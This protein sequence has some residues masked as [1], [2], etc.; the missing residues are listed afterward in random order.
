[1]Q[2][3]LE[4][5]A[6]QVI[7][8]LNGLDRIRFRGTKRLLSTVGG[9]FY[10]LRQQNV[11][12]KDFTPFVMDKT[13]ALRRGVEEQAKAW[14]HK[15]DYLNSSRTRKEDKA[16]E[17]AQQRGIKEGLVAVL[18]CV[19]PCRSYEVRKNREEQKLELCYQPMKCLHY[20]H[21]YLDRNF[22][23]VHTRMQSWFPF[24]VH[25][26]MNGREWLARQMD[27][28]GIGYVKKDNCFLDIADLPAAQKL[29]DQQLRTNWKKLLDGLVAQSNPAHAA[30]FRSL[31][32]PYYW[33]AEES[34]WASD[35]M[36]RSPAELASLM[37]RLVRHG[38]EVWKCADVLRFLGRREPE[39]YGTVGHFKG[40]VVTD[41]K[42]RPEG[43]RLLHRV[44]HN[45]LKIYDK[46]GSVLRVETVINDPRDLK[47]FRT[48]E[49]DKDGQ[50]RWLPLR[51]GV[52]DLH[53]RT[54][55]SQKANER[56]LDSLAT[57]EESQPLGA[58][59]QRLS[60]PAQ[61]AGRRVRALNPS[62]EADELLL[63]AVGR[64]EFLFNGFRNRDLRELLFPKTTDDPVEM[65]R[66]TA[67]VTRK[68]RIL[69]AHGLIQKVAKTT[70]YQLTEYGRTAIAA[71]AAA[72]VTNVK[73]LAAAA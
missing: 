22:G 12:L 26:C 56:C 2:K 54:Q 66:R 19:E 36:F 45:W 48:A 34:E 59:T 50:K 33:S 20:Y 61:L 24:T 21:Y 13:E 16:L 44:N 6:S 17:L 55:T 35:V 58:L 15:V 32:V 38:L 7:G 57:V 39:M 25:V 51:K 8:V 52:A 23:L 40:E 31:P 14:G 9:M 49:S 4:R 29:F 71:L 67:G 63:E 72:K 42:R 46:Q 70:R 30:M 11:L 27:Q 10:Y 60:Q 3:F 68:L 1:M 73:Q 41:F 5:F 65:R 43:V 47:V 64:G 69:R 37:P 18:S 28:A 62:S 53:R